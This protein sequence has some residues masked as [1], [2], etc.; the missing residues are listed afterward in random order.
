MVMLLGEW[1]SEGAGSQPPS[2][3]SQSAF[4]LGSLAVTQGSRHQ[5]S[6]SGIAWGYTSH[7]VYGGAA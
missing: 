1:E 7:L 3:C 5:E 2:S 4:L 6:V